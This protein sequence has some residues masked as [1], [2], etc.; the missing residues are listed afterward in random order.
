MQKP[1][2]LAG[3]VTA[4]PKAPRILV[5]GKH[6]LPASEAEKQAVQKAIH[7]WAK[8]RPSHP[9]HP[10]FFNVLDV[11]RRIAGTGSLGLMRYTVLVQ[12]RAS[13]VQQHGGLFLL[14]V[15]TQPGS[16]LQPYLP[17]SLPHTTQRQVA[18]AFA[19]EAQRVAKVQHWAQAAAPA[20]LSTVEIAQQ[21]CLIKE[22]L[23]TQDRLNLALL[24]AQP[25]KLYEVLQAMARLAA[26]A[27]LRTAG[28]AEADGIDTL[29]AYGEAQLAASPAARRKLLQLAKTMAQQNQR[30]WKRYVAASQAGIFSERLCATI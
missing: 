12:G 19:D 4:K 26:W 14:D 30:D 24:Q 29:I 17:L 22:L 18:H 7:A 9:Q 5:D 28:R 25:K 23:P 8:Q 15:K 20:F 2:R 21:P 16:C 6:A 13:S 27:H 11:A 10:D 3:R 1:T